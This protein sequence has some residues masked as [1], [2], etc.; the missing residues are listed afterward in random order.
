MENN[1]LKMDIMWD[2]YIFVLSLDNKRCFRLKFY[3][4]GEIISSYS[5]VAL[6]K[7]FS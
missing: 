1:D 7:L 5:Y 6:L 3:N 2:I 4:K